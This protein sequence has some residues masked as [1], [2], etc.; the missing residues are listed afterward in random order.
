MTYLLK[1]LSPNVQMQHQQ[2]KVN[3]K[4]RRVE[5]Q[6][7]SGGKMEGKAH[8]GEQGQDQ[9]MV[10]GLDRGAE[11]CLDSKAEVEQGR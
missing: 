10:A 4:S 8:E 7:Q 5:E 1:R 3:K 11:A 2:L 6:M 9:N